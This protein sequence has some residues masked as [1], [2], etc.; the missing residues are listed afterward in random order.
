M[1]NFQPYKA[2]HQGG[3]SIHSDLVFYPID[4]LPCWECAPRTFKEWVNHISF[5]RDS[6][7]RDVSENYAQIRRELIRKGREGV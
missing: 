5:C 1:N 4:R 7:C 3:G 2:F 6:R